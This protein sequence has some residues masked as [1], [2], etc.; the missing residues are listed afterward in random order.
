M[1]LLSAFVSVSRYPVTMSKFL[2]ANS[3]PELAVQAY[4]WDPSNVATNTHKKMDWLCPS[5]HVYSASVASRTSKQSGCPF[6]SNQK[7][8]P[9]FN[10]IA[11]T[12]PEI[13]KEAFGWDPTEYVAGSQRNLEWKC[14]LG[15]IF[16]MKPTT[17]TA[18]KQGCP[19]CGKQRLLQGFNDLATTHPDIAKEADGWDPSEIISGG[20]RKVNWRC[21]KGH[22]YTNTI[23]SRKSGTGCAVCANKKTLAGFNDLATTH[24]E[25]A[26]EASGWNPKELTYGSNKKVT[27]KCTE[28]H[29]W[30]AAPKSR[31]IENLNCTV[32]SRRRLSSGERIRTV[33]SSINDLATLFPDVAKMAYG[34][35]PST[36]RAGDKSVREWICKEGHI[37]EAQVVTK[38]NRSQACPFCSGRK[39]VKGQND[40]LTTHPLLAKEADGWDPSEY[41]K[42]SQK[43]LPWVC[44][45]GHRW[46]AIVN[47]RAIREAGCPF[48][49]GRTV[50]S[51]ETDVQTLYPELA[52][53]A[54]GWDP[55]KTHVGTV[56]KL[57]WRCELGHEWLASAAHRTRHKT[58]CPYCGNDIALGG[59]NDIGTT[60]PAIAKQAFEWDPTTVV[61]GSHKVRNWK[62]ELGH[63]YSTP[64][65]QRALNSGGCY[66]CSGH[67][68]LPG[69]NDLATTN[70]ELVS[71]VDGWDPTHFVQNS[72]RIVGWK[73]QLGHK[74]TARIFSRA[75]N[76][77]GCP[78]CSGF[79]VLVGF[80]DLATTHP[81]LAAQAIGWDPTT[82][83]RGTQLKKR[84]RCDVGHEWIAYVHSRSQGFGCPS[85]SVSGYDPNK[86]GWLYFLSHPHW[87]MLQIGIT[88]VPDDR[89]GSHRKLGWEVLELRGPMDGHLTQQWESA[90][91]RMLK[92]KGADL[93]NGSI[94]G[95]FDGYSEAWTTIK[96]PFSSIKE[97]MS[98]TEEYESTLAPKKE[99][100]PK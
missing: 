47:S 48:C 3:H 35:D 45:K 2:L 6:C 82:V 86:D 23:P 75:S 72:H 98:R 34:W 26:Q 52:A 97:L 38:V 53:Q 91:L 93:S 17:R 7:T 100:T 20:A 9:G 49:S 43:K 40:L 84:W 31:T 5:G 11:T 94:A 41:S 33:V 13:A 60:H 85:C 50:L 58:G 36:V 27:W 69:F 1:T 89:L 56:K 44:S 46:V 81:E 8:L 32:C 79:T 87:E 61:A 30:I 92:A 14:S 54:V 12:H 29:L 80:N 21:A 22:R 88:N 19:F 83:S 24:P 77:L 25:I 37:S 73:C 42:G 90:I 4:G 70:P 65:Y 10:D 67:K 64:I 59:F 16:S 51:G 18:Q 76:G 99:R 66:Y 95:K 55:S 78:I 68:T 63:V 74:W 96:L 71:Q 28:G 62:C 15:H 57:K 39:A